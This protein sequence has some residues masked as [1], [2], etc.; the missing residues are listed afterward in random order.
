MTDVLDRGHETRV[1]YSP[2]CSYCRHLDPDG[3]PR[4]AAFPQG[5]PRPIWEG[6]HDHRA[7]FPGD[8]GIRYSAIVVDREGAA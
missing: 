6:E 7:P 8:H 2:I 5:I 1:I 3:E 4:C